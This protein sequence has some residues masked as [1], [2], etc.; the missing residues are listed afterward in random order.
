MTPWWDRAIGMP[1][2]LQFLHGERAT[3]RELSWVYL[4][5]LVFTGVFLFAF[6]REVESLDRLRLVVLVLAGLDLSGGAIANLSRGT[7]SY[8]R[9]RPSGLRLAFLAVH[10]LHAAALAFVFPGAAMG[11]LLAWGWMMCAG[12]FLT[13]S[14]DPGRGE[15]R[16]M[17][18]ALTGAVLVNLSPGLPPAASLLLAVFL[19]KLVFSFGSAGPG[20]T[21]ES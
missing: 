13:L 10:G 8:W 15:A 12:G 6:R 3:P 11:A 2:P 18:L 9:S 5:A 16:A 19:V 14:R 1:G 4:G 20:S 21:R 17:A 7:R